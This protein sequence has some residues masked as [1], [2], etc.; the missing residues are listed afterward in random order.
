MSTLV[1][2]F[3][4]ISLVLGAVVAFMAI[5]LI[6]TLITYAMAIGVVI[7]LVKVGKLYRVT[8]VKR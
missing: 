6:G 5:Q 7:L 8:L 4:R 1:N 3:P 2:K